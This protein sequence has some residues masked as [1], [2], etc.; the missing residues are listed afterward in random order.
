MT[1]AWANA[2]NSLAKVVKPQAIK[3]WIEPLEPVSEEGPRFVVKV[4]S[5]WHLEMIQQN[6][7]PFLLDRLKEQLQQECEV[8][9]EVDEADHVGRPQGA[10][11]PTPSTAAR[12]GQAGLNPRYTFEQFVPGPTNKTAYSA[13]R[14]VAE[15]PGGISTWNPLLI[16]GDSG[17]GKT[18]LL[19]AVGHHILSQHP[20][21]KVLYVACETFMNQYI[22]SLRSPDRA[23]EFRRRYREEPDVLLVDDIQI[24]SGK[25]S[26][27]DEFF[28]T[29]NALHHGQKQIVLSSDRTPEEISDIPDRLRSRFKWGLVVEVEPPDLET[30][31]AILRRKAELSELDLPDEVAQLLAAAFK[32]NV[33]ELESAL[34][35]LAFFA[36]LEGQRR[37]TRELAE[38]KLPELTARANERVTIDNV[39]RHVAE[40]YGCKV[41]DLKSPKRHSQ[42]TKPRAVAMYLCA[43]LTGCSLPEIGRG[44]GG[45]HHTTVLAARDKI[46]KQLETDRVL[47]HE[48][49]AITQKITN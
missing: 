35:R 49:D 15:Q 19:H 45:K 31:I 43:K 39:L 47:K 41:A 10:A 5:R 29:F 14:G 37:I 8:V 24:L 32:R 44:F 13:C 3:D 26:T 34:I 28:N 48:V 33:R 22:T 4:P 20:H 23:E 1:G 40:H 30:R 2:V 16:Y 36:S 11:E 6:Y 21:W 17:L 38:A 9:F 46:A 7:L 18:H 12:F 25:N 42:I 27:Q